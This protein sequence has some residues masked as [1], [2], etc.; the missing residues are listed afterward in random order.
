MVFLTVQ[1]IL[2]LCAKVRV[3]ILLNPR[4]PAGSP[5]HYSQTRP[6]FRHEKFQPVVSQSIG[7]G[8]ENR[9]TYALRTLTPMLGSEC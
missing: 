2:R 3:E 9:Y 6:G 4:L 7:F 8:N 1:V 5:E